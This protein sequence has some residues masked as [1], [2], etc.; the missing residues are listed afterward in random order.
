MH[1]NANVLVNIFCAVLNQHMNDHESNSIMH[2]NA[3]IV[4]NIFCA[5]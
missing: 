2:K 5:V 3:T 4:A 1:K